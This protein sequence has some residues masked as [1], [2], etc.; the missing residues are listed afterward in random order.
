[1]IIGFLN[2][3]LGR[4]S[5]GGGGSIWIP[6]AA[7]EGLTVVN[8]DA[9]LSLSAVV[10]AVNLLANGI[11]LCPL[12]I[13]RDGGED[14]GRET[15]KQHPTYRTLHDAANPHQSA[16][17]FWNWAAHSLLLRGNAFA[18][19]VRD[20]NEVPRE[21]WP[22][23]ARSMEVK[24][25]GAKLNFSYTTDSGTIDL[26]AADVLHLRGP[27]IDPVTGDD[28]LKK[29]RAALALAIEAQSSA[30]SFWANATTP[31]GCLEHPGSLG[32]DGEA[33]KRLRESWEAVHGGAGNRHKVAIL[34]EG[35][36]FNPFEFDAAKS[37]MLESRKFS[38]S[39]IA[40][41]FCVP[42]HLLGDLSGQG[43][44]ST[45]ENNRAFYSHA[46]LPWLRRIE[47]AVN[48]QLLQPPYYC[49]HVADA[50]MRGAPRER[51][52]VYRLMVGSGIM[53]PNEA[54]ERENMPPIEGGDRPVLLPGSMALGGQGDS[55]PDREGEA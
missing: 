38:V 10:A 45:V 33:A 16:F 51:A 54:R 19:V 13:Y 36:K 35:M 48:M 47:Q 29:S 53:V 46:L 52:E 40:R 24:R 43:F 44:N 41:I 7:R 23:D 28:P 2:R 15:A 31:L 17:D 18:L 20:G 27:G 34:E 6:R 26:P 50:F 5:H 4:G 49:E 32:R 14:A 30:T 9:A 1:M 55:A 39:E 37:Q 22:L 25:E 12:K 3:L 8:E 11:S 21:L 42:P